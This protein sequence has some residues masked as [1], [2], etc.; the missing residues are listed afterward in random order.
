MIDLCFLE[1]GAWVL[2]DYKTDRAE[3]A[4]LLSRYALQLNWYARALASITGRPVREM[5]LFS[6][7][8]GR[9]IPV[10]PLP[11]TAFQL[12]AMGAAAPEK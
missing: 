9:A 12:C 8:A 2:T 6:L 11:E 1:E 7:R 5:Y 10:E 3:E 4:E